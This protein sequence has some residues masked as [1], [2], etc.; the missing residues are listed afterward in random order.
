MQIHHTK[1]IVLRTVKY[2]ETSIISTI[3]TELFGKQSYMVKGVRQSTKK[4]TQQ[5][6]YF[7]PAALL[8]LQV[9]HHPLKNLQFIKDFQWNLVYENIFS[10][11]VCN[12][13]A[14]YIVELLNN[15]LQQPET[16]AELFYFTENILCF[17][18][19]SHQTAA[20]NIPPYFTLKLLSLLGFEMRGEF[21]AHTF[22]VDLQEG[23]FCREVP[24]H[25]NYLNE[26]EAKITS[27]FLHVH[28]LQELENIKIAGIMRS[29]LLQAYQQFLQL[30]IP[31]FQE[32]KSLKILQEIF[33]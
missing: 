20:A 9:Y 13:V 28:A 23:V 2:G 32:I 19:E 31:D 16:H 29:R 6:N 3:Y 27:A 22:L 4:K 24:Q 26:E 11:V 15:V 33:N 14:T 17:L 10:D 1:G 5:S 8:D 18:D 7:Q 21:S 30:H 25:L 12:T